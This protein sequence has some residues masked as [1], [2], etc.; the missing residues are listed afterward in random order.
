MKRARLDKF[1]SSTLGVNRRDVRGLLASGRI[2]VDGLLATEIHQVVDQFSHVLFDDRVL[3]AHKPSY[4]ML[5]KPEGVVSATKDD[6]HR[7]VID[8][9]DGAADAA[10]G[11][12]QGADTHSYDKHSLH[13]VGR[14]DLNTTGLMLLTNDGSWSSRLTEPDKKVAKLYRVTL[15]DPVLGERRAEYIEAF[16]GGLYF[17]TEDITPRPARQSATVAERHLAQAKGD[18]ALRI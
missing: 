17:A 8:L 14:L 18:E 9:L 10:E 6:K 2:R 16:G 13:I 11:D 3:Q 1:V 15:Q 5:H 7:T 4:I 12:G